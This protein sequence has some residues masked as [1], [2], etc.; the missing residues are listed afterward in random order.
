M[1]YHSLL[2]RISKVCIV[3][4]LFLAFCNIFNFK[5]FFLFSSEKG[6]PLKKANNSYWAKKYIKFTEA[7]KLDTKLDFQKFAQMDYK[8]LYNEAID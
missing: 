6:I 3:L 5:L 4:I 8:E 7:K 2:L 1:I